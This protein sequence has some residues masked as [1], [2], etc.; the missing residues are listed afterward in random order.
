MLFAVRYISLLGTHFLS[1]E[2]CFVLKQC[3]SMVYMYMYRNYSNS[4]LKK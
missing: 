3:V 1:V 2:I 4:M